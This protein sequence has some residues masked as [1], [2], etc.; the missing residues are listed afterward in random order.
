MAVGV[1]RLPPN[2][3][4]S[5][6]LHARTR[7]SDASASECE[8][9]QDPYWK[10]ARPDPKRVDGDGNGSALRGLRSDVLTRTGGAA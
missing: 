10:A 5:C 6:A 1:V 7:E 2:C 8:N 3:A 4:L 9:M